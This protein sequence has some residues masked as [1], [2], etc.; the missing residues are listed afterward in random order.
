MCSSKKSSY[1]P[2]IGYDAKNNPSKKC[3]GGWFYKIHTK[4]AKENAAFAKKHNWNYVLLTSNVNSEYSRELLV[5]NTRAFREQG[6]AVHIMCLEDTFYIDN[7][8]TA[9]NE[10][11]S[12]LNFVNEQQLD[13][14]GIHIDCE[15]HAKKEWKDAGTEERNVIFK[16]YLEVIEYG[17]KAINEIRPDT[18]YSGAVAWWYSSITKKNELEYGRGYDLVNKDRFDFIFP[19]IYDGAGG[20]VDKVIS[21]SEDYITDNAATVIGIAISDYDNASFNAIIQSITNI[22][23][24]S[25]Y[26]NGISVFANHLYSDW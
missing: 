8:I 14:Q 11:S 23:G 20:T 12:I 22:R 16:H 17:R 3:L 5:N 19:M 26:F 21:R 7:P 6:I 1:V 24:E 9:Y 10:I 4:S 25:D 2:T 13:I 15:P 18:T